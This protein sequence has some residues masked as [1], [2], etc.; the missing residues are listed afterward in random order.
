MFGLI[1]L[2]LVLA[3]VHA[4]GWLVGGA[5]V[6]VVSVYFVCWRCVLP[7][8][9]LWRLV[10]FFVYVRVVRVQRLGLATNVFNSFLDLGSYAYV[11]N[12]VVFGG[13][14]ALTFCRFQRK[15]KVKL[16]G[17]NVGKRSNKGD[18]SLYS[19]A[20]TDNDSSMLAN[21][22]MMNE[23]S[24]MVEALPLEK[25]QLV[26]VDEELQDQER[27]FFSVLYFLCCALFIVL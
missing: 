13:L 19:V 17:N 3:F 14:A 18:V 12:L 22:Y 9:L 26:A 7:D 5:A 11:C 1:H 8:V 4:E 15:I 21:K 25:G 2:L 20:G 24:K 27:E 23:P 6:L 16:S 10:Y